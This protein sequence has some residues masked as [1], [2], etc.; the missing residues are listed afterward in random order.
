MVTSRSPLVVQWLRIHLPMQRTQVQSLARED[1]T[2]HRAL[3]LCAT[4]TEAYTFQRP[5]S[6]AREATVTR[7]LCTTGRE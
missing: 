6:A 3:S 5:C 2:C 7:S 1:P 4:T